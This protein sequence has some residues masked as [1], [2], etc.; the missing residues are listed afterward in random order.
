MAK[1]DQAC[2]LNWLTCWTDNHIFTVEQIIHYWK[3][4][5]I[6]PMVSINLGP[7]H[8]H[9]GTIWI[10]EFILNIKL[11]LPCDA[12]T[13]FKLKFTPVMEYFLSDSLV[14]QKRIYEKKFKSFYMKNVFIFLFFHLFSRY[15]Y[16][17]RGTDS[18]YVDWLLKAYVLNICI[19][20][21]D[22]HLIHDIQLRE[23]QFLPAVNLQM[24][25]PT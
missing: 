17:F 12:I 22:L 8:E 7:K 15:I 5:P 3:N 21:L 6:F 9:I 23:I 11:S 18:I 25:A 10:T 14:P 1:L 16:S 20:N 2:Q 4:N 24:N 13:F 19:S